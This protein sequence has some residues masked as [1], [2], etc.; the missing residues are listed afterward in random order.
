[1][2]GEELRTTHVEETGESAYAVSIAVSGHTIKGDEPVSFGG[3]NLG[4][5]P[6]DLL[7]AALV[8][9]AAKMAAGKGRSQVIAPE[10]R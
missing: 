10:N 1:M 4:P 7:L 9:D 2:A 5:A 3:G 6:Y 8:C